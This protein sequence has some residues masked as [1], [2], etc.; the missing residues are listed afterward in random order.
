MKNKP[1]RQ[2]ILEL[3]ERYEYPLTRKEIKVLLRMEDNQISQPMN[4]LR[5]DQRKI[6]QIEENGVK[7]YR[8]RKPYECADL[9]KPTAQD[10]FNCVREWFVKNEREMWNKMIMNI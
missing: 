3:M 2:Q 1:I 5:F 9:K 6:V 4:T 8:L 10:R 7:Y